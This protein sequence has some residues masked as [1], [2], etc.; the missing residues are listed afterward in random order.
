MIDTMNRVSSFNEFDPSSQAVF[1]LGPHCG[2]TSPHASPHA[3][4]EKKAEVIPSPGIG[5]CI[6]FKAVVEDMKDQH[7]PRNEAVQ[8]TE[9]ETRE[10]F[11]GDHLKHCSDYLV[12]LFIII[13]I[14]RN[15]LDKLDLFGGHYKPRFFMTHVWFVNHCAVVSAL[16][17]PA[18]KFVMI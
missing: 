10:I 6:H 18:H 9:P 17:H 4:A 8:Q 13:I 7:R 14:S 5:E 12:I 1:H 3:N 16:D 2:P 15:F 11:Q